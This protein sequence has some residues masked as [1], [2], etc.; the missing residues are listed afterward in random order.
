M[1]MLYGGKY[2]QRFDPVKKIIAEKKCKSVIE[3][4]FGDT[5]IAEYCK[6]HSIPWRGIDRNEKFVN[7]AKKMGFDARCEKISAEMKWEDSHCYLLI[8]SLYH[9]K[10]QSADLLKGLLHFTPLL[11]L[12][13]PVSNVSSGKGFSAKLGAKL[14]DVGDGPESFRF[15]KKSLEEMISGICKNLP[16]NYY[17]AY[18][19]KKD[20]TIVLERKS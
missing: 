10:E 8:G 19:S 7:R 14:S 6:K 18:E 11:I 2:Y 9:F 5:V 17:I 20:V 15:T 4:C 16:Y 13:E 12:N 3:I 1:Q